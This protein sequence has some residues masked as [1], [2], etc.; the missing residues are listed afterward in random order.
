MARR[1]MRDRH[2]DGGQNHNGEYHEEHTKDLCTNDE[3]TVPK[4]RSTMDG[5]EYP[6]LALLLR[7]RDRP[8]AE[9]NATEC[10][11]AVRSHITV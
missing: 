7:Q 5:G 3:F 1:F 4:G 9:G 8:G 6:C 10:G 11:Q 2:P